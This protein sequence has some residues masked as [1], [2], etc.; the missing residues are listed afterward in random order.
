MTTPSEDL[1]NESAKAA[2][3]EL[4]NVIPASGPDIQLVVVGGMA[5]IWHGLRQASQ[6]IDVALGL[7]R[8]LVQAAHTVQQR[9]D[10]PPGWLNASAS[11]YA[12]HIDINECH[13]IMRAGRITVF[14]PPVRVL[15]AMKVTSHREI[16]QADA[17]ALWPRCRFVDAAEARAYVQ[18]RYPTAPLSDATLAA[19]SDAAQQ[20]RLEPPNVEPPGLSR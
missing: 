17:T 7:D 9:L 2:I 12:P 13:S 16:D 20:P 1:D 15:F 18:D 6:D 10:L 8:D 14:V 5:M 4:A 3:V 19:I 11:G